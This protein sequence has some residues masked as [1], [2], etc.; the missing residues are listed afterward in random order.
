MAEPNLAALDFPFCCLATEF[1]RAQRPTLAPTL[2]PS[3]LG[4]IDER[5]GQPFGTMAKGM[6]AQALGGLPQLSWN[7]APH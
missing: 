7:L 3:S 1:G 5:K 2:H 4:S 6:R